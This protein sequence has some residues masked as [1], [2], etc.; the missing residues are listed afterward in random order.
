[1]SYSAAVETLLG[2][3]LPAREFAARFVCD[4]L[5]LPALP[6]DEV[7][8]W[9]DHTLVAVLVMWMREDGQL[10]VPL[11]AATPFDAF[12][13]AVLAYVQDERERLAPIRGSATT[14][15]SSGQCS[16]RSGHRAR[17]PAPQAPRSPDRRRGHSYDRSRRVLRRQDPHSTTGPA[18]D[19]SPSRPRRKMRDL[20]GSPH[21]P[22]RS[23][24]WSCLCDCWPGHRCLPRSHGGHLSIGLT[25]QSRSCCAEMQVEPEPVFDDSGHNQA[26]VFPTATCAYTFY[27]RRDEAIGSP[28]PSPVDRTPSP[29]WR[30]SSR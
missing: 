3:E 23:L 2:R 19:L 4:H 18:I 20:H 27:H 6:V 16:T 7:I 28:R 1:L 29:R 14:A 10:Q 24:T 22:R 8:G 25:R 26:I 11:D 12:R 21:L 17:S 15:R 30:R 9:P 5:V 13:A